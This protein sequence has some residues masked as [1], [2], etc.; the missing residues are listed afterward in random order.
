MTSLSLKEITDAAAKRIRELL[1][2]DKHKGSALRLTVISGGCSGMK[3]EVSI[4]K[5]IDPAVDILI[6]EGNNVRVVVDNMSMQYIAGSDLDYVQNNRLGW[7]FVISNPNST[8]TCGCGES[9]GI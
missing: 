2:Q 1:T 4:D 5:N 9:F 7:D 8:S 6:D 3:Y